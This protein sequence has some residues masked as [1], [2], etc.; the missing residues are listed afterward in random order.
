MKPTAKQ[1]VTDRRE[2]L[3]AM[4]AAELLSAGKAAGFD[5]RAGF[6]A[7]K[8]ALLA[9]GIDYEAIRDQARSDRQVARAARVSHELVL[10]SDAKARTGRFAICDAD[11]QPVWY[12]RFFDDDRDFNGEQSSG[13]MAAAKKAAWL[14]SRVA[15]GVNGSVHL[16][17]RVDA[18]WLT[19][20]N[21][22]AAGDYKTGGKARS[23]SEAAERLGVVLTVEHV[24]GAAN[25]ADKWTTASGYQRWQDYVP[26]L[27]AL[28]EGGDRSLPTPEPPQ[29]PPAVQA[30]EPLPAPQSPPAPEPLHL[31][32]P[33]EPLTAAAIAELD[34]VPVE[35][36]AN[37]SRRA[38]KDL[39][40]E[41]GLPKRAESVDYLLTRS[42]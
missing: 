8:R 6:A 28:V 3:A 36:L 5:S 10:F 22:R 26:G 27:P 13:E 21:C 18:K 39:L 11:G 25:P 38:I 7:W 42:V 2:E 12:G 34:S 19:W 29:V 17:L 32:R 14:A 9:A 33:A 41:R 20:A 1:V 31:Q 16:T 23:L 4:G 24:A 30:P 40:F 15:A 35:L 37:A